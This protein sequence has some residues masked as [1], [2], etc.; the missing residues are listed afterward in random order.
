VGPGPRARGWVTLARVGR[1]LLRRFGALVG[2][3]LFKK[4]T[5]PS[6]VAILITRSALSPS[7]SPCSSAAVAAMALLDPPERLQPE[8]ALNL[9]RNLLGW[10]VPVF[11]G[12]IC[13]GAS[14]Y[15]DLVAGEL[16]F[17]VSN[18]PSG[19]ALPIPSFF[20]LLLEGLSL[21][22]LHVMPCFILQAA[23]IAYLRRMSVG[24]TLLPASSSSIRG[25]G[26]SPAS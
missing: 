14:P 21:Q 22:P 24:A 8:V 4:G 10:G 18:L 2:E 19:L 9:V 12:K 25:E 5:P 15:D 6:A 20:V 16:V 7:S 11:A 3:S 17:F 23:I 13:V 26:C 1:G